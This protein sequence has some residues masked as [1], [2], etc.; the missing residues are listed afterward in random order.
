MITPIRHS[1]KFT[2]LVVLFFF[3]GF[4]SLT[5]LKVN[6]LLTQSHTDDT[7]STSCQC[8]VWKSTCECDHTKDTLTNHET[9]SSSVCAMTPQKIHSHDVI[10][11]LF[12]LFNPI[13]HPLFA[14]TKDQS[15]PKSNFSG[16]TTP[17]PT[18]PPK[19]LV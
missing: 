13:F 4:S 17:P 1:L 8:L 18:P 12:T 11:P 6:R 3:I 2:V 16:F 15:F 7:C 14:E 9:S 19:H 5:L 10:P